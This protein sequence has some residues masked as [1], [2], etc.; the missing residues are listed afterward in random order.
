MM[1]HFFG[2]LQPFPGKRRNTYEAPGKSAFF[3]PDAQQVPPVAEE[4]KERTAQEET[5][6][7]RQ[8]F[9]LQS[10]SPHF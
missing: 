8:R 4:A 6:I 2:I 7:E 3:G 10:F 1:V 9:L 5:A